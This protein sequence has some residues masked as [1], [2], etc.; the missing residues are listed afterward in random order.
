MDLQG[1]GLVRSG[2]GRLSAEPIVN[3]LE[4]LMIVNPPR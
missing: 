3:L 2:Q 4:R 1:T